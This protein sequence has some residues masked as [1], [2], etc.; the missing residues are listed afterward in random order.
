MIARRASRLSWLLVTVSCLLL[1][2]CIYVKDFGVYWD[3]G[4]IDPDLKGNWYQKKERDCVH[5]ATDG[6]RL[7]FINSNR[8]GD[9]VRTL[10]V[11][12]ARFL[13]ING[14]HDKYLVRYKIDGDSWIPYTL[15]SAKRDEFVHIYATPNIVVDGTSYTT[16]TINKLDAPTFAL[17]EKISADPD[18]WRPLP[19]YQHIACKLDGR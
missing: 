9:S 1:L 10:M 4:I 11:G 6:D 2:G 8:P 19:K 16:V 13:M 14:D 7:L 12:D 18:Y 15:N 17:L 5:F 3:K